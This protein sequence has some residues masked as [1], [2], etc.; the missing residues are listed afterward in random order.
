MKAKPLAV[1]RV[2]G[3]LVA[4]VSLG[5]MSLGDRGFSTLFR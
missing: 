4:K 1:E 2:D 5:V 3:V